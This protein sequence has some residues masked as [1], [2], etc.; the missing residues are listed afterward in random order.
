MASLPK[1]S[2]AAK[3]YAIFAL[4]AVATVT[5]A[6]IAVVNSR[7]HAAL[8][9]ELASAVQ[10]T[11]NIERVNGLIY[12][13]VMESRG[14]YMS[15]DPVLVK[16]YAD[17]L[18]KFNDRIGV[19]VEEW[20]RTVQPE[21]V[22]QFEAV[23][24]RIGQL[25]EFRRELVRRALEIGPAA[26]REWGD[27]ETARD[28]RKALNNDIEVL[29]RLY[30]QRAQRVYAALDEG[31]R[32]NALVLSALAILAMAL[33][34]FGALIIWRAIA[35]PLADITRAT[36]AVAEGDDNVK[37]PH[38]RRR[39]EIGA[40]AN[41]IGVFR[42]AMLRNRELNRTIGDEAQ[43]RARRQEQMSADIAQFGAEVEATVAELG[44]I[45]DE[46]SGAS[47][48]L[49]AAA[50]QASQ[51][52]AG[53][54][55]ASGE[56]SSS[57]RD[58]ASAAEELA[59]S[60][61][62]IDRQVTQS[63]EIASKA[64]DE[65]ERTGQAVRE[66]EDAAKRIG[67]VVRL[68]TSVAEQ[69]NLLALNATIEAARAGEYGRGFAVVASEVKTLAGQTAKATE[70]ISAQ[71]AG[72]QQ[73]TLRS[74]GAISSIERTIQN[75]GEITSAIAAAVT[76]QGVATREIARSAE[77]AARHTIDTAEEVGRAG[78]ATANTG[79][80]AGTVKAVADDLGNVAGRIRAQVDEFFRRLRAA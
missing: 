33:A 72:M 58:I 61:M 71:I 26:G 27:D 74:V 40:L 8:T 44:R 9:G 64:V 48:H 73:A 54:A 65:T 12:A 75:I 68:I 66:L 20:R 51:R 70:E 28:V 62:E 42:D 19:V 43:A 14:I 76:E 53:A 17:G 7:H 25:Q 41:S 24:K 47:A 35:R 2:L 18:L 78:E 56:A 31:T 32:Q 4:L 49:A 10:G 77:I 38:L 3:L 36:K 21:D 59:A 22:A 34:A 69:T 45:S 79:T 5:L 6:T 15:T 29:A 30:R 39:D 13:V 57:V 16:R 50:Q 46:M 80:N 55:S 67:D 63:S 37:V 1:L 60:V 23:A 11:V 52:T